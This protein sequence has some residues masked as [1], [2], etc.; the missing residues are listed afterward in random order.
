MIKRLILLILLIGSLLSPL[1]MKQARADSGVNFRET[2][3]AMFDL[4]S[5]AQQER[6]MVCGYLSVPGSYEK[7]D[8]AT[9]ELAVVIIKSRQQ[10]VQPD[11]I[12][13]LQ[14]GPGGSVISSYA[15]TL[16]GENRI[17]K[18]RDLVL[19]EQRGTPYSKP[20]LYCQEYDKFVLDYLNVNLSTEENDRLSTETMLACLHRI[21]AAGVDLANFNS[22][23][24]ARDIESLR[25]ALG[26]DKVNLYGV[27]YGS[28]LAQH[29]MRL[30]P[31]HLRS[32]ILD[33]VVA[34]QLNVNV[35]GIQSEDR[36]FRYLFSACQKDERCNRY[37][38]DLEQVFYE[39]V[40]KLDK[41][42][43]HLQLRDTEKWKTYDAVIDGQGFYGSIFQM[44]YAAD[45]VYALPRMIYQ[46]RDGNFT[47][48]SAI[49]SFFVFDKS[50][51]YG[52][53]Y[54]VM[55][56][57]DSDFRLEDVRRDGVEPRINEFNKDGPASFL[58]I[59]KAIDVA[60][61]GPKADESVQSD[62]PTL[63]LSGGFD[64][65]TP[66]EFAQAAA[67]NLKNSYLVY[68]PNG[69]H[70][71]LLDSECSDS[72]AVQFWQDPSHAPDAGCISKAT[73]PPFYTR[74]SRLS[75]PFLARFFVLDP[76]L[77][78]EGG[79]FALSLLGLFSAFF[80]LPLAWLVKQ[81]TRRPQTVVSEISDFDSDPPSWFVR[82]A[83]P[84][85]L[86]NGLILLG[87]PIA[88][89]V[90]LFTGISSDGNAVLFGFP[91]STWPLFL[92]PWVS[93]FL[94]ILMLLATFQG[95]SAV[96]WS[97]WRKVYFTLLTLCALVCIGVL[98]YWRFLGVL[99]Y[100]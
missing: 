31:N 100:R 61:L 39:V 56:A 52:M 43:V 73:K 10:V 64:P 7:A 62:V 11:P 4:P 30:F 13:I 15:S 75:I 74:E 48:F 28:L 49:A 70:G 87:F 1:G 79:L 71:Q 5:S 16:T 86:L 24:D 32:V 53:Y 80:V 90:L 44:L 12:I 89:I 78:W 91:A 20:S 19:L 68:F 58:N 98:A 14:G 23:D 3:C 94:A 76:K 67:E 65:V 60:Q 96:E 27:S 18:D 83:S 45:I 26:Y 69:A 57:E 84:L 8:G 36:A 85:T 21:Q 25:V 33:G 34:P 72:I 88:L 38:P 2:D 77:L 37:F 42:P 41:N 50:M 92:L 47:T 29:Y 95:W 55:C 46:V 99:F 40:D 17:L 93:V 54:T 35:L 66:Q 81:I 63:L 82:L 22:F 6:G 97:V 9:Y 51:S 59:C